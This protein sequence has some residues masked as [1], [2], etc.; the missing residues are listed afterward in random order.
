VTLWTV[1]GLNSARKIYEAAGF[2]LAAE[3]PHPGFG[4]EVVGQ[5]WTLEAL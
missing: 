4:H 3:E 5:T 1:D 2:V